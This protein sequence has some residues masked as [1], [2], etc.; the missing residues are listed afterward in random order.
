MTNHTDPKTQNQ[1]DR[2]LGQVS[3]T[4]LF[5]DFGR[6]MLSHKGSTQQWDKRGDKWHLEG[7][8]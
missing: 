4:I 6:V 7:Y 3:T 2:Y 8:S 5:S 1:F